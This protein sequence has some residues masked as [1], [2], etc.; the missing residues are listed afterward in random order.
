MKL[1]L[2]FS[3]FEFLVD[4]NFMNCKVTKNS[5]SDMLNLQGFQNPAGARL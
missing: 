5:N 2:V 4:K 3:L 1:K